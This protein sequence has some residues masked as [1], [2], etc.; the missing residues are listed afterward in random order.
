MRNVDNAPTGVIL[1]TTPIRP[2]TQAKFLSIPQISNDSMAKPNF[3]DYTGEIF[4]CQSRKPSLF[5]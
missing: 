3:S 5:T 4:T 2:E 1:E